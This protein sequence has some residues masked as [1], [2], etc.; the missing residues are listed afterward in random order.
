[1]LNNNLPTGRYMQVVLVDDKKWSSVERDL[2]Y[3]VRCPTKVG[4]CTK[5][6][7]EIS[8]CTFWLGTAGVIMYTPQL[9]HSIRNIL[10]FL[11]SALL[12][13]VA[14]ILTAISVTTHRVWKSMV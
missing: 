5:C 8:L 2:L 9:Q 11:L 7:Q 13:P 6:H 12:T 1:M 4:N 14:P 3:Q 10:D